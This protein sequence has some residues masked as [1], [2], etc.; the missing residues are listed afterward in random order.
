MPV[1]DKD[2]KLVGSPAALVAALFGLAGMALPAS[3]STDYL[4]RPAREVKVRDKSGRTK[5][6]RRKGRR[7]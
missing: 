5:D 3:S 4:P 6:P 7:R 2:G 1:Y